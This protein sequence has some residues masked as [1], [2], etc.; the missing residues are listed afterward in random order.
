MGGNHRTG[1]PVANTIARIRQEQR[2]EATADAETVVIERLDML[3]ADPDIAAAVAG[4]LVD[5]SVD[6]DM[7]TVPCRRC[8]QHAVGYRV[9]GEHCQAVCRGCLAPTLADDPAAPL[10]V[11]YGPHAATVPLAPPTVAVHCP[12]VDAEADTRWDG[13]A[14]Y[15]Q[16]CGDGIDATHPTVHTGGRL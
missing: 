5:W 11:E 7:P 15:C 13:T 14:R 6:V 1:E 9:W 8:G 10:V 16:H 12:T 3:R 4:R 2:D